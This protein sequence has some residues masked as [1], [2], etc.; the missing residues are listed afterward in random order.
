MGASE[1]FVKAMTRYQA[2][3]RGFWS[4]WD[5][6]RPFAEKPRLRRRNRELDMLTEFDMQW[7]KELGLNV[8]YWEEVGNYLTKAIENHQRELGGNTPNT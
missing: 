4:A 6:T 7:V 1:F 5:F 8:G 3:S 2:F